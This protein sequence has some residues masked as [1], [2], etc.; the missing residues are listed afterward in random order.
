[1]AYKNETQAVDEFNAK[2]AYI[3]RVVGAAISNT[4]TNGPAG[5]VKRLLQVS[6]LEYV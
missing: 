3:D 5:S 1:M 6:E 2:W 4:A